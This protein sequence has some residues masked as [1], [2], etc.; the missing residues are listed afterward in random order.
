MKIQK[1]YETNARDYPN[2]PTIRTPL[3][4]ELP[5][6]NVIDLEPAHIFVF[7]VTIDPIEYHVTNFASADISS[8]RSN[9]NI[10]TT[11]IILKSRSV[12]RGV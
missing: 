2:F 4:S 6:S 7:S 8:K 1:E 11:T 3:L 9:D 5:Y 10:S 12:L